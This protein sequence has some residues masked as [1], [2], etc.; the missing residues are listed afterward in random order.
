MQ[1]AYKAELASA[2]GIH[3]NSLLALNNMPIKRYADYLI[4]QGELHN[5]MQVRH[6]AC[7][8][9]RQNLGLAGQLNGWAQQ[10]G[11]CL[12]KLRMLAPSEEQTRTDA[13]CV[14]IWDK[15]IE[16]NTRETP[17]FHTGLT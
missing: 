7:P 5:Y 6:H 11:G 13:T 16:G 12:A 9:S 15:E 17:A 8:M 14:L 3:F 1:E 2:Y 10:K 4:R